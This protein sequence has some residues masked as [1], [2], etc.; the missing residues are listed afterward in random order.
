[1]SL[2]HKPVATHDGGLLTLI[3]ASSVCIPVL[4]PHSRPWRSHWSHSRLLIVPCF[5]SSH[6]LPKW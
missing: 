5:L 6:K 3:P 2:C 1:M 4:Q